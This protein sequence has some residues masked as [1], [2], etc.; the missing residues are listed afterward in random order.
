MG[1]ILVISDFWILACL[2]AT[3]LLDQSVSFYINLDMYDLCTI[4]IIDVKKTTEAVYSVFGSAADCLECRSSF[5]FKHENISEI[6]F[7]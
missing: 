6:Q 5:T 4:V 2:F 7:F 3:V 1:G